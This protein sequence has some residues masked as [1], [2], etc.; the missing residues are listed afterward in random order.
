MKVLLTG[1]GGVIGRRLTEL[2]PYDIV[3]CSHARLDITDQN[4]VRKIVAEVKPDMIINCAAVLKPISEEDPELAFRVNV[5]GVQNLLDT[6]VKLF[7]FSS[8]T[9][10]DPTNWYGMTKRAAEYLIDKNKNV[11]LR[12]PCVN[13]GQPRYTSDVF[14]DDIARMIIS[15]SDKTGLYNAWDLSSNYFKEKAIRLLERILRKLRGPSL[16]RAN[17]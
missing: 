16:K 12:L 15:L 13:V 8:H 17:R 2:L 7:H 11:I 1:A 5:Q 4:A 6:G 9:A 10:L 3:P 14:I